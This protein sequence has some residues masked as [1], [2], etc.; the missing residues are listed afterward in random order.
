MTDTAVTPESADARA[1]R[2]A[3]QVYALQLQADVD[4]AVIAHLESQGVTAQSEI[5]ALSGALAESIA[6]ARRI[7][8]A[9]GYVM[10]LENLTDAEAFQALKQASAKSNRRLLDLAERL[11]GE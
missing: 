10:A 2:L 11:T 9:I 8:T 3:L 1:D 7:G 5:A 6:A 4:G